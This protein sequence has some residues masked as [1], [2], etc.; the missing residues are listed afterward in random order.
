MN[1]TLPKIV[2]KSSFKVAVEAGKKYSWCSCGL[3]AI[4]PFCDGAHKA[5]KNADGTSVMKSVPYVATED[6]IVSFCGCKHSKN[7]PLCDGSHLALKCD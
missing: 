3:S 4:Q 2:A 5:F 6:K 1:E 7:G